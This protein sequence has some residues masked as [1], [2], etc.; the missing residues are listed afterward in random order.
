[1]KAVDLLELI[2]LAAIW[3]ASFM[4]MRIAAPAFG[5]FAMVFL[6]V[7]LASLCLL[8]WLI[9]RGELAGLRTHW[10]PLAVVGLTNSALPF[11]LFGVA[12]MSLSA[13]FSAV[14]NA[15]SPIWAGVVAWVWLGQKLPRWR[16][17]GLFA[18]LA[19]V[20]VLVWGKISFKPG[21][22]GWAVLA[23]MAAPLCYGIAANFTRERL[24]GVSPM[25]IATGSQVSAS[26]MLL[27]FALWYWPEQPLAWSAWMAVLTLALVCT[28]LAYLMYFRLI[29]HVG[30]GKAISVT[31]LI[32]LFAIL[33]SAVFLG[34]QLTRNVFVGGLIIL[35]G[36]ALAL[37]L[38]PR[39]KV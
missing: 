25:L 7:G 28:A 38:W 32:P 24:S 3:G 29:A 16:L 30:P 34:E 39:T 27:P 36:T 5:P 19:G 8:P 22:D 35:S 31:F 1:M 17:L 21:G 11:C 9:W 18:G 12:A 10:R 14:I 4:V 23:V 2:A 20:L 15:T 13:G 33:L 26:L 6:R 37:G